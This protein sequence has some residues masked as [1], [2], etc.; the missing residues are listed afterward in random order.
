M[1]VVGKSK[2][3]VVLDTC[4]KE[5]S[6]YFSDH[7]RI[8]KCNP[9]CKNIEYLSERD[10]YQWTFMAD[11][12]RKNPIVALFFV[13]QDL[14][15]LPPESELLEQYINT[16]NIQIDK[17]RGGKLIRW[18]AAENIPDVE[19]TSENTFI[20]TAGAEICLLHHTDD[21]TSVHYDTSITLDFKVPFPLN[22]MPEMVLKFLT[23]NIM[24]QIMQQATE[25]ML[26]K[27]QSD[28]CCWDAAIVAEGCAAEGDTQ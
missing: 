3:H 21:K 28:I 26:C 25:S 14:E 1:E 2:A 4:L 20:G 9:Y 11:D 13:K 6:D 27:V 12:P 24:S 18:S 23:E 16:G 7:L 10:I 17:N 8:L 5:S 22:M 19:I 15:H